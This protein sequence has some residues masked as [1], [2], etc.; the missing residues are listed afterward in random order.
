[1]ISKEGKAG[2]TMFTIQAEVEGRSVTLEY[3]TLDHFFTD[4]TLREWFHRGLVDKCAVY[5]NG[6]ALTTSLPKMLMGWER[7]RE[8][9]ISISST[10]LRSHFEKS[11]QEAR[12]G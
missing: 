12:R 8:Q 10:I 3:K 5:Q 9:V 2:V 4:V 6:D 11:E 1:M 7:L